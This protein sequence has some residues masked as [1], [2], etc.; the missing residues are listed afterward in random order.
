MS[1]HCFHGTGQKHPLTLDCPP[2]PDTEAP[3]VHAIYQAA[4]AALRGDDEPP[5]APAELDYHLRRTNGNEGPGDE[6]SA[7][8]HY[9][10][11]P[12]AEARHITQEFPANIAIA[13]N[14]LWRYRHKG[15]PTKDLR[16]AI[17]HIQF[18]IERIELT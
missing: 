6:I 13:M 12:V 16:K 7:P 10:W 9:T 5:L 4:I 15:T 1:V 17:Q 11:H 14:Y 2:P 18:E 8:D 3:E